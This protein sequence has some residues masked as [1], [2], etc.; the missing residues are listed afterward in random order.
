MTLVWK[1]APSNPVIEEQAIERAKAFRGV[2]L[3]ARVVFGLRAADLSSANG[4]GSNV[5]A[6]GAGG[7]GSLVRLAVRTID[8]SQATT[9]RGRPVLICRGALVAAAA[10]LARSYSN[11]SWAI[12]HDARAWYAA[13]SRDRGDGLAKRL[14]KNAIERFAF[15]FSDRNVVVS[16][17]LLGV[18]IARGAA[19]SLTSV[20]PPW[21]RQDTTTSA[22]SDADVLYVG[23]SWHTAY[24]PE[25]LV[26]PFL[27]ELARALP[28]TMLGWLDAAADP[29]GEQL[30]A[31]LWRRSV[32]PEVVA[33]Y[34]RGASVSLLIREP[35]L[36]NATAAPTKAAQYFAAGCGV[37]TTPFPPAVAELC[38][39]TGN[40]RV[41][42]DLD[43]KLWAQAVR[44]LMAKG[45]RRR[46]DLRDSTLDSWQ[47]LI[48]SL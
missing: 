15:R 1:E 41:V 43:P 20:I 10:L 42:S 28:D 23:N 24:Q 33:H 22:S 21:I 30:A 12:V 32:P 11:S 36:T 40:G 37:V 13:F 47:S 27:Q 25:T 46:L 34:L 9:A 26:R 45:D 39:V 16:Q 35:S 7:G 17:A 4:F 14:G 44:E 19:P 8:S 3:D 5:S 2:G 31:N 48:H 29:V 38:H 18:A 6:V